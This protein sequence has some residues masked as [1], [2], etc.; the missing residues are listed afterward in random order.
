MPRLLKT[1]HDFPAACRG[2]AVS[3]GNFDGVHQGH[4]D[5]VRRLVAAAQR[6]GG[7]ATAL[8]F[9]PPPATLLNP[10]RRLGAPLTTIERRAELLF[11]LG[12]ETVIAYPT[13]LALL[14]LS[15]EDFFWQKIVK[16]LGAR[17]MVEGPNF[18]F[19]R[20]R[21]GGPELLR[22]LCTTAHIE[23]EIVAATDVHHGMVSSTRIRE[24]LAAGDI[25]EAN[26]LLT[27]A[28][29]LQGRVRRGAQR[30]HK[31]GFPTANLEQ[32][33]MLIPAPGVYTGWATTDQDDSP[34][35]AAIHIGPNPT[36]AENKPK[37]EIHLIDFENKSLYDTELKVTLL[38]R[39]RDVHKFDSI[40]HLRQQLQRD[41]A[42]CRRRLKS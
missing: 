6:V 40:E 36:F 25:A 30:G 19:G 1:L 7:P 32:I 42:E 8:T 38:E 18:H 34:R 35:P 29:M 41:I 12:V 23:L 10:Q 24:L 13:D 16:I 28:Y 17:A 27:H 39:I 9:D 11:R 21:E 20:G 3:V 26:Q 2:G 15:A 31:L 33:P 14:S 5:L 37:V 4:A 22:T